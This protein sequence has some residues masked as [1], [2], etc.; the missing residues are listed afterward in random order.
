MPSKSWGSPQ[1]I[2][3]YIII[4][5]TEEVSKGQMAYVFNRQAEGKYDWVMADEWEAFLSGDMAQ[6]K[7][8]IEAEIPN[9]KVRW[10]KISWEEAHKWK[11]DPYGDWIYSVK[12]FY[13]EAIVENLG[14]A[15]LTGLEIVAILLAVAF[16]AV[17]IATIFLVGWTTWKVIEATPKWAIPIVGILLIVMFL[18]FVL[19]FFGAELGITKKKVVIKG[20]KR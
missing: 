16:V 18:M 2:K 7:N 5:D 4:G 1:L 8:R 10:I 13:I 17:V 6:I 20:R 19:I 12:G 9:T 11:P 14:G 15:S 3:E